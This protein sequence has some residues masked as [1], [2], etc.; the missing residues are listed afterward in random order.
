MTKLL[1]DLLEQ[2]EL[3]NW[4]QPRISFQ[5]HP[6]V[7]RS[8]EQFTLRGGSR[9]FSPMLE[10]YLPAATQVAAGVCT[11]GDAIENQVRADF[12]ASDRL[13]AVMLDEIGTL[14]LYRLGDQLEKTIHGEAARL[15]IEA[16]GALNPGEDTFPITQQETVLELAG[17]AAIGISYTTTGM[18]RP[19]KTLSMILGLGKQMRKWSRGER[20]AVCAA[21]VRCPHRRSKLTGGAT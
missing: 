21:R 14:A 13:R 16:S 12:A 9:I 18:L 10:H 17:G 15:G 3:H 6:I 11:I 7:A 1:S 5:V 19:R 4:I 2:I 8:R 20:C